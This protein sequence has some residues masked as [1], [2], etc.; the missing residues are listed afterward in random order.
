[1]LSLSLEEKSSCDRGINS[2]AGFTWLWLAALFILALRPVADF[3]T[4]WQLQSGKYIWQTGSFLYADTFSLAKDAYRLEHCWLS[5]VFFFAT[6]SLGGFVLLGLLKTFVITLCGALLLRESQAKNIP[7][8]LAIPVLTICLLASSPAWVERPQLWT[9]CLS[10]VYLKLLYDGRSRGIAS[11]IWL[12]PLMIVWANLHAGSI[13][14]LVLIALF[15]CGEAIRALRK[16]TAWKPVMVLCGVGIAAFIGIFLNPYGSRI[17]LQLLAHFNLTHIN[18]AQGYITEW[19]PTTTTKAPL[20]YVVFSLW[21]LLI[22][23]RFRRI[24]P[25]ELI[26]FV[27]FSYMG[28]NQVRHAVFVPLLAGFFMPSA[29]C[30]ALSE[31][32]QRPFRKL[33]CDRVSKCAV[34]I[35]MLAVVAYNGLNGELG[36]G[37]KKAQFPEAAATF[38]LA[39]HLPGNLYNFYDHGGYLMWRLYPQYLV[40]VD[41]RNTDTELLETSNRIDGGITGWQADLSRHGVN[42]IITRTC[43]DDDGGPI[44]LVSNLVNDPGWALVYADNVA[45]IFLRRDQRFRELLNRLEIPPGNAYRTMF[46]EAKRLYKEDSSRSM[47]IISLARSSLLLGDRDEALKYYRAFLSISPKD[48]EALQMIPIL[49]Q[50]TIP[51]FNR[52]KDE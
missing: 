51:M 35:S 8:C 33:A 22:L 38:L 47:A 31:R 24:D 49:E 3:D 48:Q 39:N 36:I 21:A 17:P 16:E 11:W 20:F 37:L 13:F 46:L 9:F 7:T 41:G 42:T 27:A 14:G 1:M 5:D 32:F 12:V 43:Y 23:A 10:L 18:A 6:Y 45:V 44:K 52:K 34:A 29:L 25:T 26:F 4:F 30:D 28:W 19:L 2:D 40:F 15:W 50:Q